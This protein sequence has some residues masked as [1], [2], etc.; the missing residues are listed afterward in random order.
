MKKYPV[1]LSIAGSDSSSGAGIQ[2]DLKAI[3]AL[4]AYGATAITA[5][6]IQNTLGVR[7][8]HP[9]PPEFVKGQ[10]EAVMDDLSPDAIKIG[11]IND[12]EIVRVIAGALKKYRPAH[13]VF[14]PVMIS[15]SGSKLINDDAIAVV[16]SELMPFTDLITPNLDEAEVLIEKKITNLDD[17]K[18]AARSLLN[19]GSKWVLVKGGHLQGEIMYDV[20]Q[21][22]EGDPV[23][24]T[25]DYIESKNVHGTGCTLSS[26]IATFLALGDSMPKAVEQAK[27]YITGAIRYGKDVKVG[28]GNGPLN[29]F[30]KPVPMIVYDGE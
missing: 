12:I 13:V 23:I 6:T 3:S 25:G 2:A 1:I 17:M 8:I 28:H 4:G 15:T 18:A 11:M 10:I 26:S 9:V 27:A 16:T 29:H 20:L 21:G 19:Y 22:K 5:I 30:W 14:D 7:A 24:F